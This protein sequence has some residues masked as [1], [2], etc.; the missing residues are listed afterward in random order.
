MKKRLETGVLFRM[1]VY[2]KV[3]MF[4]AATVLELSRLVNL[5]ILSLLLFLLRAAVTIGFMAI[6]IEKLPENRPM[7]MGQ[8]WQ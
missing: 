8:G 4:V 2:A 7:P 1:A 3:L 5:I 6:A